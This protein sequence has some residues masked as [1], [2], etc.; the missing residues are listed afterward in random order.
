MLK[1]LFRWKLLREIFVLVRKI[2]NAARDR[3]LE[4]AELDVIHEQLSKV[5]DVYRGTDG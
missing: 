5:I 2:V 1:L 3:D 4:L